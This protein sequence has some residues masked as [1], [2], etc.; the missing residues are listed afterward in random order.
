[1]GQIGFRLKIAAVFPLLCLFLAS[2]ASQVTPPSVLPT[3]QEFQV[4]ANL[5]DQF[6]VRDESTAAKPEAAP[7]PVAPPEPK[8]GKKTKQKRGVKTAEAAQPAPFVIENRWTMAP[9]FHAG[10][11]V[12]FDITYFGA[13]AGQ[14]ELAT[15]R[16]PQ[17][18]AAQGGNAWKQ[19]AASGGPTMTCRVA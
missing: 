9:F 12:V 16:N 2:C 17:G 15:V 11:K 7:I 1:M 10:E 6:A 18:L 4:P 19:T 8:R 13:T 5:A 3:N 14:L